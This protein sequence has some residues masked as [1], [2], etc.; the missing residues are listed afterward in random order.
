LIRRNTTTRTTALTAGGDMAGLIGHVSRI[1][2]L[3]FFTPPPYSTDGF[4]PLNLLFSQVARSLVLMGKKDLGHWLV[5]LRR[6][7]SFWD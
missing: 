5:T 2:A 6:S 1:H 7:V 3:L 4:L